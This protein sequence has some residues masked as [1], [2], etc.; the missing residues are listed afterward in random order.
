MVEAERVA[1]VSGNEP[2]LD[3]TR[4]TRFTRM[5]TS[6]GCGN[7]TGKSSSRLI[8]H[9]PTVLIVTGRRKLDQLSQNLYGLDYCGKI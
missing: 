1:R 3:L 2:S 9:H 5:P 4:E 6:E 8:T 7:I